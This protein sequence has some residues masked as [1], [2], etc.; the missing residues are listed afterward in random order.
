MKKA[1]ILLLAVFLM[2]SC[3]TGGFFL[4]RQFN[5]SDVQ[6][7]RQETSPP[8]TTSQA[9]TPSTTAGIEPAPPP[10][11]I[12]DGKININTATLEQLISLP[13]I[14]EVIAQRII[15]YRQTH[16][17]FRSVGELTEVEGIGEKRMEAILEYVT[18][19]GS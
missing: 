2:A 8:S 14:G 16:G 18:I 19:G 13:T 9:P 12:D 17:P 11:Q 5:R 1:S 7:S 4:G 3:L 10:A 15:A 6:L